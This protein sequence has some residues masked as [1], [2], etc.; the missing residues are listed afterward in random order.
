M[1][2]TSMLQNNRL[3]DRRLQFIR[4]HQEAFDVE[5]TFILSLFEEAVLG[6][7]GTCGVELMCHVEGDQLFAVDFQVSNE[8]HTWP[9]SLT[10]AV[11]FLDKVESQVGVRLNR[12]LLQQF[13]AVH[14][15]S[16]KIL[17]NTIGIDL[18]P[19]HEN[20]CIKVYM[21]IEHEEDP[22]ELVRTAL[23][24]DGDSYSS[25]MLQVLLKSTII[26]GFNIF[27]NGY[28]DVELLVA[29]VGDKYESHKFNRGKYL[30]HYIQK[31]FSL[32][33]NYMLR[34][35]NILLV[36]FSQAKKVNPLLIFHY[37]D[38]KDIRKYFSFNS[39][40]DRSYSFFQSQDCITYAGVSVRELELQKD[41][42]EKF[43]LFYNKRDKCQHLPLFS[44]LNE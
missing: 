31:N 40:G 41:R 9:R 20:S 27:F 15:G 3:K 25:E 8:R 24:L 28:S 21:H 42:L 36:S 16:S 2:L 43:S 4:T 29:T 11:K 17:N 5:P 7:E 23:K 30:K 38:I 14:I 39:L 10:D 19:R 26:I 18:R 44:T 6:I 37:E 12:D 34:E 22:E 1:T 33:A 32:K 35:S 13:V